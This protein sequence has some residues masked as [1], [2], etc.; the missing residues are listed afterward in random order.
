[1]LNFIFSLS[2]FSFPSLILCGPAAYLQEPSSKYHVIRDCST[3][4][5]RGRHNWNPF[6]WRVTEITSIVY[7]II[8][9]VTETKHVESIV[10]MSCGACITST[11]PHPSVTSPADVLE[12]G[13][14]PGTAT[15]SAIPEVETLPMRCEDCNYYT[16]NHSPP[17]SS[18]MPLSPGYTEDLEA[19]LMKYK[20][21]SFVSDVGPPQAVSS[22]VEGSWN[23]MRQ[24][25]GKENHS[26][27]V[28]VRSVPN[29]PLMQLN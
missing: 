4:T 15:W 11:P 9:T 13:V 6:E 5:S 3:S 28:T 26:Y 1:M 2:L 18:E 22:G 21:T 19:L 27:T 7:S 25:L 24:C 16:H 12:T 10:T 20:P 14:E 23:S 17:S 29:K 8:I